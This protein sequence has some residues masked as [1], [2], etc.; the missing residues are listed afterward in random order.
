MLVLVFDAAGAVFLPNQELS[1][2]LYISISPPP[3]PSL[4]PGCLFITGCLFIAVGEVKR[5]VNVKW[6]LAISTLDEHT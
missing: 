5:I 3:Q 1:L 6:V 2:S 4:K